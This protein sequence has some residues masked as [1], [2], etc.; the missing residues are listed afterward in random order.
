[1]K[2][3]MYTQSN[4]YLR[5]TSSTLLLALLLLSAL[6]AFLPI[7]V[8]HG[9]TGTVDLGTVDS[10]TPSAAYTPA[11]HFVNVTAG[12]AVAENDCTSVPCNNGYLAINFFGVDFSGS[13]FKLYLST[14]G[15]S[16]INTTAG[17]TS[18]VLMTTNVFNVGALSGSFGEIGST[19]YYIGTISGALIVAGPIPVQISNKYHFIKVYD[20]SSSSVAAS[21]K[22]IGIL[23]GL[24]TTPTSGPAGTIVTV[25][26]GGFPVNTVINL[27]YSFPFTAFTLI[28]TPSTV[29]GNWT[30]MT[31][32]NTGPGYFTKSA[33]IVDT[34]QVNNPPPIVPI[35]LVTISISATHYSG[36]DTVVYAS[37]TFNENTRFISEVISLD[38]LGH[39]VP[40]TAN[41]FG[42]E[43]IYGNY[44]G[45]AAEGGI[46]NLQ[47]QNAVS[48]GSLIIAGNDSLINSGVTFW[49]GSTATGGTL[50]QIGSTTSDNYGNFNGTATLPS[51]AIGLHLIVV[52]NN[53][54]QYWFQIYIE[55]SLILTDVVTN[56]NSGTV[57]STVNAQGYGFPAGDIVYLYW[58]E[59]SYYD[60]TY[61][62]LNTTTGL[63]INFTVPS[64]GHFTGIAFYVP[65]SFGG[66]HYV[67]ATT[68]YVK[69]PYDYLPATYITG[70]TFTVTPSLI[71]TPNTAN[72]SSTTQLTAIGTGFEPYV[73]YN[74]NLD[75]AQ[76]S[77]AVCQYYCN[78]YYYEEGAPVPGTVIPTY[79]GDLNVTFFAAGFQ[80]GL[81]VVSMYSA[82]TY[83][84]G[85][86]FAPAV[87]AFFHIASTGQ[88]G[89]GS[90]NSTTLNNIN[91]NV[92][93]IL[94]KVN[95]ILTWQSYITG[96]NTNVNTILTWQS[97]I[98]GTNTNV[99]T[100]LGWKSTITNINSTVNG[101]KA[102]LVT[103]QGTLTNIIGDITS[104]TTAAT[105]AQT[106]AQAASTAAT[107][108][109]NSISDTETYV[110]VVAVLAAITLVLEL[111]IL[112]RKLD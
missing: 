25:S 11:T 16:Q 17:E 66:D 42:S 56:T 86:V 60:Y 62:N 96:T 99:N 101:I 92:I 51:L 43:N 94:S 65:H 9:S 12:S 21:I 31:G 90:L 37:T 89:T 24:T 109:K 93:A 63:L 35:E 40:P 79:V 110:L 67:Y 50:T 1:M 70:A 74:V 59:L 84:A 36:I 30:G 104:A 6:L 34:K 8:V 71:V 4:A 82:D 41:P 57:G 3:R 88:T 26:G 19:G 80:P 69:D 91:N 13:Q 105:A 28:W 103:I 45:S 7:A 102:T 58:Y 29:T 54:V 15:F 14:N 112:V 23:P 18:D 97:Y 20:G 5:K 53:G 81:H 39:L 95:T 64:N 98:T 32:I 48:L 2:I 68:G 49:V 27:N 100:I 85:G 106:A 38:S 10:L 46:T 73:G 77:P 76:Y 108:T 61:F 87:F 22:E 107:N 33:A 83:G 55:P 44:N 52:K 111:A 47:T 75:G 72:Y 78:A